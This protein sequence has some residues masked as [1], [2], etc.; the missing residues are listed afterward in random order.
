MYLSASGCVEPEWFLTGRTMTAR[1]LRV[2]SSDRTSPTTTPSPESRARLIERIRGEIAERRYVTVRKLN[3]AVIKMAADLN[4]K[5]SSQPSALKGRTAEAK[6]P[7]PRRASAAD[8]L[9]G[10]KP[11]SARSSSSS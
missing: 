6:L 2:S 3:A 1:P 9:K 7:T 5:P 4:S 10:H 11:C 8:Y